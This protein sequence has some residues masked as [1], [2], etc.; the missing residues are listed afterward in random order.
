MQPDT[1]RRWLHRFNRS[2]LQGLEDP[3]GQG[4]KRQ[5]TEAERSM[6]LG[7]IKQ[8]APGRLAVQADGEPAAADASG[9]LRP[10]SPGGRSRPA[11]RLCSR[12]AAWGSSP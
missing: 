6:I 5:I 10:G 11:R 7:L 3:G 1:A 2:G 8:V 12:P 4:R 9:P